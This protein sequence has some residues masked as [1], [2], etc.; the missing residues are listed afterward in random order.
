VTL[1]E[2][3]VLI[4]ATALPENR[5]GV[6]RFL[7]AVIVEL[8]TRTDLTAVVACQGRDVEHF[9]ALGV[10]TVHGLPASH[11]S[12]ARRM[13]WEQFG[14]PRLARRLGA[15]V[16]YSP[17]Y[18]FPV[19]GRTPAVV[20]VHDLTFFTLP[21][22]H[23]TLKR[24]F[25]KTW[26]RLGKLTRRPII[27][28]SAATAAELTRW[29]GTPPERV[30]VAPHG[31]DETFHD[32][33]ADDL[34][35]LRDAVP[36]LPERWIA[37]LGTL[38]PRKNVPA[39]IEAYTRVAT[40]NAD[41]PALLLA[42]GDGWD[43]GVQPAIQRARQDGFDVRRLGYLP[44]DALA[45]FLGGAEVVAYPSLGEGFGLPVLEAMACGAPVITTRDAA[46]AEVGGDAVAYSETDAPSLAATLERL[47]GSPA[48]T[49][50]LRDLARTRAA[51][52]TWRA[53][54]DRI[55]QVLITTARPR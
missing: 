40:L 17:H 24:L 21:D 46:L 5:G 2:P 10:H 47:L 33:T 34:T 15:D 49:L 27:V 36:D 42:G 35:R 39:L 9:T 31:V 28:P 45:A 51:A 22:A 41:A 23:S 13:L 20:E 43:A 16:I 6:G 48:E 37:F 19:L 55:A 26:I 29:A 52:F 7:D 25:F 1:A 32:P 4:D 11:E 54:A 3:T 53:S 38:E 44:A 30:T 14:L 50:K 12:R 18:T 8:A